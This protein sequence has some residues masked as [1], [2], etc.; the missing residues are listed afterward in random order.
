MVSESNH[1]S[2]EDG[3]GSVFWQDPV[4]NDDEFRRWIVFS[5]LSSAGVPSSYRSRGDLR[6][7]PHRPVDDGDDRLSVRRRLGG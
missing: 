1:E 4:V 6:C 5:M 2:T 3:V 7:H